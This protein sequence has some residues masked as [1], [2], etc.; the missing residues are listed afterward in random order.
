MPRRPGPDRAND[1]CVDRAASPLLP[2]TGLSLALP[3]R[4]HSRQPGWSATWSGRNVAT[5]AWK[6]KSRFRN[7]TPRTL[8]RCHS[9]GPHP[10]DYP[11]LAAGVGHWSIPSG[12]EAGCRGGLAVPGLRVPAPPHPR[13]EPAPEL[14]LDADLRRQQWQGLR[15]QQPHRLRLQP[16]VSVFGLNTDVHVQSEERTARGHE[17]RLTRLHVVEQCAFQIRPPSRLKTLRTG[18]RRVY[19]EPCPARSAT[20]SSGSV[21]SAGRR[22]VRRWSSTA[23]ATTFATRRGTRS[24]AASSSARSVRTPGTTEVPVMPC[25]VFHE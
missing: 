8:E 2:R 4:V 16:R 24:P 18:D 22:T 15:L 5:T 20:S 1:P 10:R 9:W 6:R 13:L 14:A 11:A 17:G 19:S 23:T 7:G 21:R 12:S 25:R 3:D